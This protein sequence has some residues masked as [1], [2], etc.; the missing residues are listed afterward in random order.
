MST[1]QS[2]MEV[3]AQERHH[4]QRLSASANRGN[5]AEA[6]TVREETRRDETPGGDKEECE[7]SSHQL[8][9]QPS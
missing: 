9:Q 4:N 3:R 2:I 8:Q 1:A 6:A 5:E 7:G